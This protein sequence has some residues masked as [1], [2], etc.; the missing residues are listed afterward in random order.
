MSSGSI[1]TGRLGVTASA[2]RARGNADGEDV[3][4]SNTRV[5]R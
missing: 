1:G 5:S 2:S 4:F 3:T